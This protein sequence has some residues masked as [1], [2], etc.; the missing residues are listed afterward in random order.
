M[1][2][3]N[4]EFKGEDLGESESSTQNLSN[5]KKKIPLKTIKIM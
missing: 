4:E 1:I 5:P 3:N 2:E